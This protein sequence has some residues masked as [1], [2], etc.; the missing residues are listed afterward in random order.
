MIQ[1]KAY[2]QPPTGGLASVVCCRTYSR[3]LSARSSR[4]WACFELPAR[5]SC[6]VLRHGR[7]GLATIL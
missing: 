7:G 3:E 5:D 6:Y 2:F 4:V 1:N